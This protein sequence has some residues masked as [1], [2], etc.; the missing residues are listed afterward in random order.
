MAKTSDVSDKII[1]ALADYLKRDAASIQTTHH[2][3]D[4]LGLDSMAVIEMLYR[5]E[6]VFNLQIPDQD[7][8]GLTTV[9]QVIAYVQG[10]VAPPKAPAK[11]AAK[12]PAKAAAKPPAAKRST[13]SKKA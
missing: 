13:K 5:I 11:A 9:G 1:Q 12:T 7:L 10:R 4:D 2:L 8:V 3:R 6:E